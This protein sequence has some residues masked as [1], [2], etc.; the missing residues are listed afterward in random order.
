MAK[1]DVIQGTRIFQGLSTEQLHK[2][3]SISRE[4]TYAAGQYIFREG[5][6]ARSLYIIE[7]GKVILEMRIAPLPK[8]RLSPQATVDV[9]IK[10]DIIAWSALVE[11]HILTFSA[12]AVDR[13]KL[14]ALDGI[15]LLELM[16][17]DPA[18]GYEIM[19][20]LSEVIAS[21]LNHTR[22]TLISERGLA[23]LSQAYP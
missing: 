15:K 7:E 13:C 10:G 19:R 16:D 1:L 20:R 21:R 11:P 4:E 12:Q 2:L 14:I 8:H 5:D 22:Q 18:M 23:L 17:S 3:D 9:L 6:Q